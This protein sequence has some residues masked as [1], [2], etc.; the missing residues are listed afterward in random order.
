MLRAIVR[1]CCAET[2][3]GSSKPVSYTHLYTSETPV[4][5]FIAPGDGFGHTFWISDQSEDIAAITAEFA[6]MPA[7]DIAD[8]HHRSAAAALVGAE[9]AKQ[10]P[11]HK[12]DEEYNLSLI[13]I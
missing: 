7:R 13:H 4:Y 5:D 8:G 2:C 1:I 11:N 9:K 6:K 3:S 12:G 10:N